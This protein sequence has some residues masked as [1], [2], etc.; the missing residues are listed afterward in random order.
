MR[1]LKAIVLWP[2]G[3]LGALCLLLL[4]GRDLYRIDQD[5]PDDWL[6]RG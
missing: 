4:F 6:P 3:L 2:L 5:F 1:W